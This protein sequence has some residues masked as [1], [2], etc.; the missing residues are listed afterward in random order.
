MICFHSKPFQLVTGESTRHAYGIS[1]DRLVLLV[2]RT[3]RNTSAGLAGAEDDENEIDVECGHTCSEN[4]DSEYDEEDDEDEEEDEEDEEEDDEDEEEDEEDEEEDEEDEEEDVEDKEEDEEEWSREGDG[5]DD[6]QGDDDAE[7]EGNGTHDQAEAEAQ[8]QPAFD[9]D[10]IDFLVFLSP[11]QI[12]AGGLLA[13]LA[14]SGASRPRLLKAFRNLILAIFTSNSA[15][16]ISDR[17]HSPVD[18][19]LIASRVNRDG[20]FP[21]GV[22]MSNGFSKLQYLCLFSIMVD[23]TRHSDSER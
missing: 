14:K 5:E 13:R 23:V 20:S 11:E 12:S 10:G 1:A 15:N 22:A 7:G 6:G 3:L 21:T 18:A 8:D 17:F 16:A 2:L 19:F 4:S 9:D